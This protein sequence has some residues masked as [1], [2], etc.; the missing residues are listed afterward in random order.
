MN[1]VF[2]HYPQAEIRLWGCQDQC[3]F[4]GRMGAE[5]PDVVAVCVKEDTSC[6]KSAKSLPSTR[7]GN[8]VH[9]LVD[10]PD[11]GVGGRHVVVEGKH[12]ATSHSI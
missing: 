6:N 7:H 9:Y 5:V 1:W 4:V 12:K 11:C 8:Q 2:S 3:D 10:H